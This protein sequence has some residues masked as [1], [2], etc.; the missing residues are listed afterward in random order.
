MCGFSVRQQPS[1]YDPALD[2]KGRTDWR[3]RIV[4]KAK[5]QVPW[6][7]KISAKLL[8]SRLPVRTATWQRF[9]VFRGSQM[10]S[11][12]Y[13]QLVW[14]THFPV[15]GFPDLRDRTVLEIGP[16]NSL[17]TA[18]LACASGARHVWLVDSVE[19]AGQGEPEGATYLT[20]G[21][22][23]L[24][25]LPDKSVDFLFSHA[26]LE[27]IRFH[28]FDDLVGEMRRLLKPGGIVSH[29]IDFR[30]HLQ[31][32]L[33][34]YRF[35]HGLWESRLMASSGFYTNRI[36]WPSMR[37]RFAGAGFNVSVISTKHWPVLPIKQSAMA[38]PFRSMPPEEL[39][40]S[41]C[42]CVLR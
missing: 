17:L 26:V 42:H 14:Q 29:M 3:W 27:H 20:R 10:D 4:T 12:D 39:L 34:S 21:L 35:S 41:E 9:N 15:S 6:Y 18:K 37:S 13:A 36:P 40:C 28:E 23:S 32:S 24:R 7:A 25:S 19:L 30:D 22:E 2:P 8:L 33:N 5:T 1:D 16:G 31:E 11:L 38:E